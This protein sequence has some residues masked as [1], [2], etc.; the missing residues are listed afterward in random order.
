[1]K[2]Q[3][4]GHTWVGV[5]PYTRTNLMNGRGR[6]ARRAQKCH[7]GIGHMDSQYIGMVRVKIHQ[8]KTATCILDLKVD[9]RV[10]YTIAVGTERLISGTGLS[11][12]CD[13]ADTIRRLLGEVFGH[14]TL[15]MQDQDGLT[16]ALNPDTS[17]R[18]DPHP[19]VPLPVPSMHRTNATHR[20]QL[21]HA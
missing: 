4:A 3:T 12:V 21:S 16:D 10:V 13:V 6:I 20:P 2:H 17:A 1:M 18:G 5:F 14:L 15:E 9:G 7:G 19:A 8:D 11:R